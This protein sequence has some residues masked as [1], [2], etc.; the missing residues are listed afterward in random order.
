MDNPILIASGMVAIAA[1]AWLA[2]QYWDAW[3][4]GGIT[5]RAASPWC[6]RSGWVLRDEAGPGGMPRTSGGIGADPG[7]L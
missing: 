3:A 2:A 7:R 4:S 1:F 6:S 5:V